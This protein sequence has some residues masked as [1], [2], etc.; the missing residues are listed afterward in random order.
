MKAGVPLSEAERKGIVIAVESVFLKL[1]NLYAKVLPIFHDYGFTA[2]SA[3]VV[4][5][6]LSEKIEAAIVQ[7]CD[8]FAK[9]VAHCDLL[10]LDQDWEV[11][12]C[13]GSG[14]T[15]NQSKV[16]KGENYIVVNYT[17][18]STVKRVW[19]LWQAD[20]SFFTRRKAHLNLRRILPAVAQPN[21]EVIFEAKPAVKAAPA[22]APRPSRLVMA[23][24]GLEERARRRKRIPK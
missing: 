16:I 6:D 15:I 10:R 14:L 18:Y 7:H 8:T 11:K 2:Q 21:V 17:K 3:G 24:A 22:A 19:V 13:K 20:D 4:A 1:T 23:K 12:V 5:R 9:G